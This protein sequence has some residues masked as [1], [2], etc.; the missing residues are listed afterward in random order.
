MPSIWSLPGCPRGLG[1]HT[2]EHHHELLQGNL[3]VSD[4]VQ[5]PVPSCHPHPTA[6]TSRHGS[7]SPLP[8]LD[9]HLQIRATNFTEILFVQQ[10][11]QA[12][13][14]C[15]ITEQDSRH[16]VHKQACIHF[17]TEEHR[18]VGSA[19]SIPVGLQ[20]RGAVFLPQ[21]ACVLITSGLHGVSHREFHGAREMSTC[22]ISRT[23]PALDTQ[24]LQRKH[25]RKQCVW[26][27]RCCSGGSPL[28]LLDATPASNIG[29]QSVSFC[30]YPQTSGI[31]LAPLSFRMDGEAQECTFSLFTQSSSVLHGLLGAFGIQEATVHVA[32]VVF[33]SQEKAATR[34]ADSPKDAQKS[35]KQCRAMGAVR[36]SNARRDSHNMETTNKTDDGWKGLS[37]DLGIRTERFQRVTTRLTY[38]A[39]AAA[40]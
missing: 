30:V 13:D 14:G 37:S 8:A 22:A 27:Q 35:T 6:R 23:C 39:R 2:T 17:F 25:R 15:G 24:C 38:A 7:G 3:H 21:V 9:C 31:A 5:C 20:Q 29:F 11:V 16:R 40:C 1:Q 19:C 32:P 34:T 26:V 18:C 28:A 12:I 36:A 4:Q 10:L 33:G